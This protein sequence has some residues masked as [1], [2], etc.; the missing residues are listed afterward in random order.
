MLQ[1]WVTHYNRGRPHASVG[2]GIPEG[3]AV[4]AVVAE[5][6]LS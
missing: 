3:S 2:P 5:S 1:E 4:D 6:E